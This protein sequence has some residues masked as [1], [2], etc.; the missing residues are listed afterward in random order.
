[1]HD[2]EPLEYGIRWVGKTKVSISKRDIIIKKTP[3]NSFSTYA[4]KRVFLF[5]IAGSSFIM[6]TKGLN[7]RIKANAHRRLKAGAISKVS[8]TTEPAKYIE[9]KLKML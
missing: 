2:Q 5:G 3:L 8:R 7:S 6:V 4:P 1:M 9:A